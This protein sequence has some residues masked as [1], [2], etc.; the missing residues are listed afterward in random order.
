MPAPKPPGLKVRLIRIE[1]LSPFEEEIFLRVSTGDGKNEKFKTKAKKADKQGNIQME[2][3]SATLDVPQ[4][5]HE[6]QLKVMLFSN[7]H[8]MGE[9]AM[10]GLDSLP[11]GEEVLSWQRIIGCDAMINIALEPIG[12]GK[13]KID[14][15]TYVPSSGNETEEEQPP[16]NPTQV[17]N[18]IMKKFREVK[19]VSKTNLLGEILLEKLAHVT[20]ENGTAD[21][22]SDD[23]PRR[24]SSD[25]ELPSSKS[26]VKKSPKVKQRT[27][28]QA[29]GEAVSKPVTKPSNPPTLDSGGKRLPSPKSR[30]NLQLGS[31][32][33]EKTPPAKEKAPQISQTSKPSN[34]KALELATKRAALDLAMQ[35]PTSRSKRLNKSV[36]GTPSAATPNKTPQMLSPVSSRSSTPPKFAA[37]ANKINPTSTK[38]SNSLPSSPPL[39]KTKSLSKLEIIPKTLKSSKSREDIRPPIPKTLQSSKSRE[40]IKYAT[41]RGVPKSNSFD[42][43]SSLRTPRRS[44]SEEVAK[45]FQPEQPKPKPKVS[46][47]TSSSRSGLFAPTA[48]SSAKLMKDD[49]K[50]ATKPVQPLP[51]KTLLKATPNKKV[52]NAEKV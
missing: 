2:G 37:T 50:Q 39:Q 11:K 19:T 6:A 41:V 30:E 51:F 22:D 1:G 32:K 8:F 38:N 4:K 31:P 13:D 18:M 47:T 20:E 52:P 29:P 36:G 7:N 12:F 24:A 43:K 10:M 49:Q 33:K 40:D 26:V 23:Q 28:L 16:K 17:Y 15:M 14:H 44:T 35:S 5:F 46:S 25:T 3:I 27:I 9:F 42:A 48:S 21:S 45:L 34:K